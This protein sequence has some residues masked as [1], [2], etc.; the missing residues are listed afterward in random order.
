MASLAVQ[1]A[2]QTAAVDSSLRNPKELQTCHGCNPVRRRKT[3]QA[4]NGNEAKAKGE[5]E[6]FFS[7][8]KNIKAGKKASWE[9]F[10]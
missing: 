10:C 1:N 7:T 2:E 9:R 5:D 3:S 6:V 4:E 8:C